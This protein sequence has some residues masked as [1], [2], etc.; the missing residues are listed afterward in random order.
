MFYIIIFTVCQIFMGILQCLEIT[1]C[2]HNTIPHFLEIPLKITASKMFKYNKTEDKVFEKKWCFV[3]FN[4]CIHNRRSK[5]QEEKGNMEG[6]S[7]SPK[8][9]AYEI[10]CQRPGIFLYHY[11]TQEQGILKCQEYIFLIS[12][13]GRFHSPFSQHDTVKKKKKVKTQMY[14]FINLLMYLKGTWE[15]G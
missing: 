15:R 9:Q 3:F 2:K 14:A 5:R 6:T 4:K 12:S 10:L 8:S 11:I 13:F 1:L 7:H